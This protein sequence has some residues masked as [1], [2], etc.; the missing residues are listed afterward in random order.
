MNTTAEKRLKRKPSVTGANVDIFKTKRGVDV[1]KTRPRRTRLADPD[2][3]TR[4]MKTS[5]GVNKTRTERT[6]HRDLFSGLMKK[7]T[8]MR[9]KRTHPSDGSVTGPK[10]TVQKRGLLGKGGRANRW[11]RKQGR[12]SQNLVG[13]MESDIV[14][15]I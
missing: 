8:T 11:P 2:I 15:I 13:G 12:Q 10:A 1:K 5:A 7:K 9:G 14:I 3:C 4:K 6:P